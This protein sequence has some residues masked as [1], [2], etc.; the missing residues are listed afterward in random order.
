M[1]LTWWEGRERNT[2]GFPCPSWRITILG[3]VHREGVYRARQGSRSPWNTSYNHTHRS[4]VTLGSYCFW[5]GSFLYSWRY[6]GT[7][8]KDEN[9]PSRLWLWWRY[10][11]AELCCAE[12]LAWSDWGSVT[13]S[14]TQRQSPDSSEFQCKRDWPTA[15][16][17]SSND[18]YFYDTSKK[19]RHWQE[20]LAKFQ[21]GK[22]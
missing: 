4:C 21:Y 3:T 14:R 16:V 1:I 19:N 8:D 12:G 9:K 22:Q 18:G 11:K 2:R 10:S 7:R 5:M 17:F 13:D 20:V 6:L 15:E